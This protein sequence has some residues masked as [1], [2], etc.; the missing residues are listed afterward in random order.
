MMVTENSDDASLIVLKVF[1]SVCYMR[2]CVCKLLKC[3]SINVNFRTQLQD[4]EDVY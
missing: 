4:W 1:R 2:V 3:T